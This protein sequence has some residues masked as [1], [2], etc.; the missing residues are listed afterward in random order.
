MSKKICTKK[1]NRIGKDIN[2]PIDG[3]K[4]VGEDG[5]VELSDECAE[6]M[7]T[8]SIGWSELEG[9]SDDDTDVEEDV[10]VDSEEV[11]EKEEAEE[12]EANGVDLN[13]MS[14]EELKSVLKE[15]GVYDGRKHGK[16]SQPKL[17]SEI[18]KL[19]S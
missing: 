2:F 4:T 16:M 1:P 6:L 8:K 14:K 12:A 10:D 3:L 13:D 5:I 9:E 19:M 18:Q 11:S 15:A 7:L 17:I